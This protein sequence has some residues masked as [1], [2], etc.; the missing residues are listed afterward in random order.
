M[1]IKNYFTLILLAIG[2]STSAQTP[3]T[4]APNIKVTDINGQFHSLFDYLDNGQYALIDFFSA[5]CG[6][7]NSLARTLDTVYKHY[8]ENQGSLVILGIDNFFN[9]AT[10]SEFAENNNATF[11][12]ASGIEGNGS[13]MHE[14]YEIPYY[15]CMVLIAPDRTILSPYLAHN[16]HAQ[17]IIDSL[18]SYHISN[19]GIAEF[20][21]NTNA[22]QAYPN[23]A[24]DMVQIKA[25]NNQAQ[26]FEYLIVYN[27]QGQKIKEKALK[28]KTFP[29]TLYISDWKP[30][31]YHLL[32]VDKKGQAT[33][34]RFV[35]Q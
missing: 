8:Q 16:H 21:T 4:E 7:C 12:M 34:L 20:K 31:V 1:K 30:G 15:P 11:P 18:K 26:A 29:F 32:F 27:T 14:L 24:T 3:L 2:L 35:K 13:N 28:N 23:P 22:L 5:T 33:S 25:V 10:V 17:G 19:V 6:P 9:D